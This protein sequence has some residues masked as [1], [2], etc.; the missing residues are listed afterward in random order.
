[1]LLLDPVVGGVGFVAQLWMLAAGVVAIRQALDFGIVRALL[2]ALLGIVP[3]WI[4]LA[5]VLH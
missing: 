3:Y 2:T 1:M 5:L 4:V